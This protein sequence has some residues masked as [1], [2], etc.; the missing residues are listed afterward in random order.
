MYSIVSDQRISTVIAC[1]IALFDAHPHDAVVRIYHALI[2]HPSLVPTP[3]YAAGIALCTAARLVGAVTPWPRTPGC[4][5]PLQG[6]L[7]E[8]RVMHTQTRAD[9]ATLEA[10][11]KCADSAGS[12]KP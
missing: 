7:W 9:S 6:T 8:R 10:Q 1:G 2:S 3:G 11:P 5:V 4:D 12:H